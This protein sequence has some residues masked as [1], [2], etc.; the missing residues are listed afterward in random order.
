MSVSKPA[1]VLMVGGMALLMSFNVLA[2]TAW[3]DPHPQR[4]D[5]FVEG[6]EFLY[7]SSSFINRFSYRQLSQVPAPG[8]DGLSGT[9]GSIT[10]DELYLETS[11]QKTLFF[12]NDTV[13]VIAR[14]QR[15][16]DFDGRF[17]RQLLGVVRKFGDHWQGILSA[18]VS[19]DK[20]EIDFYYEAA[21]QPD[22][23]QR[24]RLALVQVDRLY[25]NKGNSDNKYER[26]PVTLFAHYQYQ[27]DR[28]LGFDLAVNYSP[29]AQYEDRDTSLYIRGD[30]LRVAGSLTLGVSRHWRSQWSFKLENSNRDFRALAPAASAGRDAFTRR[31]RSATFALTSDVAAEYHAGVRYLTLDEQGWFGQNLASSGF[32]RRDELMLF[33]GLTVWRRDASWWQPTLTV[34]DI[35]V[36]RELWQRPADNRQDDE[37]Q[38]RLS[39]PWRYVVNQ[40][41]GAIL[42]LNPTL[43]L[44]AM[45]FGGG[46]IQLHWPF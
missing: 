46:N 6:R 33:A 22:S 24:L 37:W 36:D 20:G 17:D 1:R 26:T 43:D 32:H 8:E 30:Q 13:G 9:G 28:Y 25:N 5:G 7:N 39:L 11:L 31:M 12:D 2:Q 15:R 10:G 44:D 18:D 4:L 34:G 3:R 38:A 42:T 19:G 16:E 14:V 27:S 41:S 45:K 23:S 21:W 29:H 40:E 35:E